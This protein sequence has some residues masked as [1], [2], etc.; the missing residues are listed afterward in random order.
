MAADDLKLKA[1]EVVNRLL[2]RRLKRGGMS[3]SQPETYFQCDAEDPRFFLGG[4]EVRVHIWGHWSD[5][6]VEFDAQSGEPMAFSID[7]YADP[8]NQEEISQEK[9]LAAVKKMIEIPSDAVLKNFYHFNFTSQHKLAR[10]EWK[11]Y[12]RGLRVDGDYLYVSVHPKTFRIV[13]YARKWR[14]LGLA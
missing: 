1:A 5:A 10:L 7:R 11:R 9:A 8:P 2:S 14:K 6:R 12:H 3:T 4:S 13:E